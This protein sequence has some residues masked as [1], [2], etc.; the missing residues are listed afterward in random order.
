M[1][2]SLQYREVTTADW[3]FCRPSPHPDAEVG[4][5]TPGQE[6]AVLVDLLLDPAG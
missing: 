2:G 6:D 1:A 3:E 5:V 4:D